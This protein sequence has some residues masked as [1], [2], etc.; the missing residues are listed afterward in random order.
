MIFLTF[1]FGPLETRLVQPTPPLLATTT[2]ATQGI[3]KITF[4][5]ITNSMCPAK[6]LDGLEDEDAVHLVITT[7][8]HYGRADLEGDNTSFG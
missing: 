5:M 4:K 8:G 2:I 1:A 3:E 6:V 7:S